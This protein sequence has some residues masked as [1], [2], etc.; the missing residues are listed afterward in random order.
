[1]S[2]ALDTSTIS[3]FSATTNNSFNHTCT[4]SNLILIVATIDDNFAGS[5]ATSVTY[6]GVSLTL[7][8]SGTTPG[9]A[10]FVSLWYLKNPATGTHTVS[11][12]GQSGS[13]NCAAISSSYTGA[14]QTT[15]PDATL[16]N[17]AGGSTSITENL[18]TIADNAWV[19]ALAGIDKASNGTAGSGFTMRQTG[20]LSS[21]NSLGFGLEDTNGVVHPAGSKTTAMS[22]GTSG[23]I[24]LIA[25]SITPATSTTVTLSV[26]SFSLTGY[27]AIIGAFVNILLSMGNFI[28][29][30]YNAT[31]S[32]VGFPV[33]SNTTK[34]SISITNTSKHNSTIT[35]T[36]K[37]KETI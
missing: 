9:G 13:G 6:N 8:D 36:Q 20:N 37:T 30:G 35:N 5:H 26:G 17:T 11:V 4:G 22:F 24:R 23:N 19:I 25:A 15:Q 21:G 16:S 32:K 10:A 28:V 2:I 7:I 18:T 1:M 3:P 33:W 34:H 31:L 27:S 29:T 12:Q 14:D